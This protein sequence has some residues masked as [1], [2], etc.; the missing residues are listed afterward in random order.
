MRIDWVH[1]TPWAATAGGVLIGLAAAWL[2]LV[3]GRILGASGILG[4]V[5]TPRKDDVAWR[6]AFLAGLILS[7][8]AARFVV[9]PAVPDFDIGTVT[10]LGGGILVGFGTQL[11]SGCTSGHGVCGL[12]RLSTRSAAATVIFMFTAFAIVFLTRHV[13]R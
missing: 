5:A 3:D 6:I 2:I 12:A 7:P 9:Q 11:G 13:W 1:F 10:L 4:G 8:F